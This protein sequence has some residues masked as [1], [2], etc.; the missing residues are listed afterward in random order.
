MRELTSSMSAVIS[1]LVV[2][3][4]IATLP[5]DGF[6]QA[7]SSH[8]KATR[9]KR[10]F[11]ANNKAEWEALAKGACSGDTVTD[12]CAHA[13]IV[14]VATEC[15]GSARFFQRAT[16]TW[17]IVNLG[18]IL[19]SAAFTAVGASTTIANA[20]IYSTLG[21]TTGLGAVTTTIN[22]NAASDQTG[23]SAVNTTLTNFLAFLKT[24]VVPGQQAGAAGAGTPPDNATIYK[25]APVFAGQCE[26]AATGSAGASK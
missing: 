6:A 22:A 13:V 5:C 14:Q 26:A 15:G 21:G 10:Q 8:P 23:L 2:G 9:N 18:L 11:V 16:T 19:A 25:L 4:L 12:A 1:I 24:G 3:S 17:Q 7:V 20:K